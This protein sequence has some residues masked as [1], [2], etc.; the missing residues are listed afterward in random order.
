[1]VVHKRTEAQYSKVG[2]QYNEPAVQIAQEN[3]IPN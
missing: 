1:M 3:G 2:Y